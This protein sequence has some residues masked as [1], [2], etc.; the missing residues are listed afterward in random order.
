MTAA[1]GNDILL[2]GDGNDVLSDG[3]GSD[4][5]MAML[6]TTTSWLRPTQ[7]MIPTTAAPG[8]TLWIIPRPR[9]A[10]R[11][12]SAPEPPRAARPVTM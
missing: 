1:A 5:V 7:P 9:R 10:S 11:L 2:G 6:A 12:T 4:T 3:T 8:G